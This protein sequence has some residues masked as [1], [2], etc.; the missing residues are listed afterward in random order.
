MS[1]LPALVVTIVAAA[2]VAQVV[3]PLAITGSEPK[4]AES[5]PDAGPPPPR[6]ELRDHELVVP[7]RV[8]FEP[9]TV[10]W[11]PESV[12]VLEHVRAYLLANPSV[13]VLRVEAH[14][15]GSGDGMNR[16]LAEWRARALAQ[17][18]V[19]KGISCMRVLPVSFGDEQPVSRKDDAAARA[20]NERFRFVV[21]E[22]RGRSPG[23]RPVEGGGT[24]GNV[25]P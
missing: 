2:A 22:L 20:A 10:R 14:G 18:L 23:G 17:W 1:R 16:Q 25:C 4:Q 8:A 11:T 15:D 7:G 21:A 24:A 12:V 3:D 5:A 19:D 9:G 13:T 6:F